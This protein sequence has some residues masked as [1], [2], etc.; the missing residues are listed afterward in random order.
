MTAILVIVGGMGSAVVYLAL[1]LRVER[2]EN[3]RLREQVRLGCEE[4]R[5]AMALAKSVQSEKPE[6]RPWPC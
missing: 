2:A 6:V 1:Q 3:R 4:W 5:L